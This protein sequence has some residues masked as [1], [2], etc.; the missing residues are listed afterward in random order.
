MAL[1]LNR[2]PLDFRCEIVQPILTAAVQGASVCVVG[3]A[4]AGKSNLVKFIKQPQV[5]AHYLP[6]SLAENTHLL[7][8]QCRPSMQSSATFYR[9]LL[10][11]LQPVARRVQVPLTVPKGDVDYYAVREAIRQLCGTAAQRIVLLLDEFE[12]LIQNQPL[13]FFEELRNLRDEVRT[14]SCF[15]Y[16][17]ITHRLP[18]RVAGYQRFENS[19]LYELLRGHIYP[20]GP[21]SAADAASMLN[22]LAAGEATPVDPG[23]LERIRVAAGGH[24]GI[25]RAIFATVRPQFKASSPRLAQLAAEDGEVRQACDHLWQHLHSSERRALL[26][27]AAGHLPEPWLLDFLYKRG[28]LTSIKTPHFFAP[29]FAVYV[30]SLTT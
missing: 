28:L 7:E 25:M 12:C 5:L 19:K 10:N 15:A 17:A 6:Q 8:I 4:G 2:Y 20:L 13:E 21:Y 14:G 29:A 9:A 23:Y 30:E 18:H 22:V 3:L 26:D 1:I 24:S 11:E 16:G 27:L